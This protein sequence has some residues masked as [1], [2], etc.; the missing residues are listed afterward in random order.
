[1]SDSEA[2]PIDVIAQE[3]KR[4][5]VPD[6]LSPSKQVE[7]LS[8]TLLIN[9]RDSHSIDTIRGSALLHLKQLKDASIINETDLETTSQ[10]IQ[11]VVEHQR[12]I[13][14]MLKDTS[15]LNV[16]QTALAYEALR[17]EIKQSIVEA[18]DH[19]DMA[20]SPGE[21]ISTYE[22]LIDTVTSD[23]S[24]SSQASAQDKA[25]MLKVLYAHLREGVSWFYTTES[26]NKPFYYTKEFV[27]DVKASRVAARKYLEFCSGASEPFSFVNVA[28]LNFSAGMRA[29]WLDDLSRWF[30]LRKEVDRRLDTESAKYRWSFRY[31]DKDQWMMLKTEAPAV[32][33]GLIHAHIDHHLRYIEAQSAQPNLDEKDRAEFEDAK[34]SFRMTILLD[35]EYRADFSTDVESL[36]KIGDPD[37]RREEIMN[38]IYD[39]VRVKPFHFLKIDGVQRAALHRQCYSNDRKDQPLY[40]A[41]YRNKPQYIV[42]YHRS[43]PP[44]HHFPQY[45][46]N[47]DLSAWNTHDPQSLGNTADADWCLTFN[48]VNADVHFK[49][50]HRW[51]GAPVLP[52][53]VDTALG[54]RDYVAQYAK[55][56][57]RIAPFP[58]ILNGEHDYAEVRRQNGLPPKEKLPPRHYPLMEAVATEYLHL[59]IPRVYFDRDEIE[60]DPE[61]GVPKLTKRRYKFNE[62]VVMAQVLAMANNTTDFQL[63]VNAREALWKPA[64]IRD[65][66][67]QSV[68][69][70]MLPLLHSNLFGK[71]YYE[72]YIRETSGELDRA[73]RGLAMTALYTAPLGMTT[74]RLVE[75]PARTFQRAVNLIA[76][77]GGMVSVCPT[78]IAESEVREKMED[79]VSLG[80][81]T[82]RPRNQT[83]DNFDIHKMVDNLGVVGITDHPDGKYQ[84]FRVRLEPADVPTLWH[85]FIYN[86]RQFPSERIGVEESNK[87]TDKYYNAIEPLI[88]TWSLYCR[89]EA[90]LADYDRELQKAFRTL[91]RLGTKDT[92]RIGLKKYEIEGPESLTEIMNELLHKKAKR[93]IDGEQFE[94]WMK[95]YTE[96]IEDDLNGVVEYKKRK[97]K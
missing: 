35:E 40:A 31:H 68:V 63:L 90:T 14:E 88:Q 72:R 75:K 11:Q 87:L 19:L 85:E 81:D 58:K 95:T 67:L 66:N 18:I 30:E 79:L 37:V 76:Q 89:A 44:D 62:S 2:Q 43:E 10:R 32:T 94:T 29:G 86:I 56:P 92:Y 26:E 27:E 77:S 83:V 22:K 54:I 28:I 3:A 52:Y 93:I 82:A 13:A 80:F 21:A 15:Q 5:E 25:A 4:G 69:I 84:V 49:V 36:L 50:N 78:S 41:F 91:K 38:R 23:E 16:Q 33:A 34:K 17:P 9:A 1:M 65:D 57:I 42:N 47:E 39:F 59:E 61:G 73:R 6:G 70:A 64:D 55:E 24:Y 74:E 48:A 71:E 7:W 45:F 12:V 96:I 51:N 46:D 8:A 60:E 20:T 53:V 97:K